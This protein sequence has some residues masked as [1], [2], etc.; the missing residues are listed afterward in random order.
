MPIP[1]LY[2]DEL[3]APFPFD[4]IYPEQLRFMHE[5]K[6]VLDARISTKDTKKASTGLIEMPTGTGK[7][8]TILT[9]ALA[10][11]HA[12]PDIGK[13]FFC[14]R[15]IGEMTKCL[16]ELKKVYAYQSEIFG[17][18]DQ[19]FLALGV[20]SRKNL[21]VNETAIEEIDGERVSSKCRELT[22]NG[23][24]G[25][26]IGYTNKFDPSNRGPAQPVQSAYPSNDLARDRIPRGVF[27]V[28]DLKLQGIEQGWCPYYSSRKFVDFANVVVFS[29]QFLIDEKVSASIPFLNS[30]QI[31]ATAGS[32]SGLNPS[33]SSPLSSIA[34]F[35]EAHNI[36]DVCIE[37]LTVKLSKETI[38]KAAVNV[39]KLSNEVEKVKATEYTKLQDE[40]DRLMKGLIRAGQVSEAAA[41]S[42]KVSNEEKSMIIPGSIRKAENFV[43]QLNCC[44]A[45]LKNYI[46]VDKSKVEGPLMVLHKL[47]EAEN[48]EQRS[49]K[50]FSLRLRSLVST[51]EILDLTQFQPI[52]AVC[53]FLSLL[54]SHQKGFAILSDPFPE[55]EGVYEPM[56]ELICLD[57]S[58]AFSKVTNK[59]QSVLLTSGT[60]SPISIYKKLLQ[61]PNLISSVNLSISLPRE[62]IK[63]LI[64]SRGND[65]AL[66]STKFEL[67]EDPEVLM[68]YGHLIEELLS[69]AVT[70]GIVVFFPSKLYM[71]KICMFWFESGLL[72]RLANLRPLFF[73]TEDVIETTYA[74]SNYKKACDAGS[75]AVFFAVARGKVSEGIDFDKHYGRCVVVIGV[76]YQYVLSRKLR[77]RLEYYATVHGIKESEFLSFDA[78]RATSQCIGRVL[79]NKQDY[80]VM[81]LADYRYAKSDKRDKLPNWIKE[82]LEFSGLNVDLTVSGCRDFLLNVTQTDPNQE[83]N[84][85]IS[86]L[87]ASEWRNWVNKEIL[88]AGKAGNFQ[89]QEENDS[90]DF[91]E[92]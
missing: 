28:D 51:L 79:R 7:T 63:P 87:G 81:I 8:V 16:Q 60:L 24:C 25:Y 44:L 57:P 67:R 31:A 13:I 90:M 68:N 74:L 42:I 17:T 92:V 11:Q 43:S 56:C 22:V 80:G 6:K 76:P 27:S 61:L 4:S 47:N 78:M 34:I 18:K 65:N 69:N 9:L 1:D 14:T 52:S 33:S 85:V 73:E 41:E 88:G 5:F 54:A 10:Y 55:T 50:G 83:K 49:L 29:Y 62:A 30:P 46:K 23:N 15:T 86:E 53:N 89:K 72:S 20:S 70:D 38:E 77:A 45:F 3:Q 84:R 12:H 2:I 26:K 59:F 21:C 37:S 91:M 19:H 40:V 32:T 48:I 75:G 58:I 64:V 36:D 35:D 71:R 66:L 82:K 39:K